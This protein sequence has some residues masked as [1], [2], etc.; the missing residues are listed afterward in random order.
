MRLFGGVANYYNA[1]KKHFTVDP[2]FFELGA[3]KDKE[4]V[5]EKPKHLFGDW[6]RFRNLIKNN[7]FNFGLIHI[8]PSFAYA[9][10]IRE[11]I[12]LQIAKRFGQ[13]VLVTFHGWNVD[14]VKIVEK[15]FFRLFFSAFN[16][17][18]AFIVLASDIK[19]QMRNWGFTQPIFLETTP[20][21]DDLIYEFSIEDRISTIRSKKMKQILFLSRIEKEK[22]IRETI[23]AYSRLLS[24][25]SSLHLVIAGEG[26][27]LSEAYKLSKKMRLDKRILFLGYVKGQSKRNVFLNSDIYVLPSYGEGMPTSVLEAM[28]FGLPVVTRPVGGLKDFFVDGKHGFM[29]ESKDP[30]VIASLI[31]KIVFDDKLC[32]EMSI[33]V[34]KTAMERFLASKVAKRLENI[35]ESM[36]CKAVV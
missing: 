30:S 36:L 4:N 20:V 15:Y 5:F 10:L 17:A 11:A 22:G 34:H 29:T 2:E 33:T 6:L 27:F 25:Y 12:L 19:K 8:N 16:M 28:A 31:K 21:D 14:Y 7:P 9:S 18:D 23:E 35:Y 13:K 3:L 26:S 32:Q 24:A 1:V